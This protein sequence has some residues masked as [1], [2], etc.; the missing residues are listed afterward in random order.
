MT[1]KTSKK[2]ESKKKSPAIKS[3]VEETET[4]AEEIE[5]QQELSREEAPANDEPETPPEAANDDCD[6]TKN[7]RIFTFILLL[8]AAFLAYKG[9]PKVE[10]VHTK[11]HA[12][13]F[14]DIENGEIIETLVEAHKRNTQR[15]EEL[16]N[17][18]SQLQSTEEGVRK[19]IS[20]SL[21]QF[22]SELENIA[23]KVEKEPES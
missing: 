7:V 6:A 2:G 1:K 11:A 16:E 20:A 3:K 22:S 13:A 15:I 14:A 5:E 4:Q 21:R 12:N 17:Y 9:R 10:I 8:F 19:D 23:E 18:I